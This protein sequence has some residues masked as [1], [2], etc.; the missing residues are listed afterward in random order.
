LVDRTKAGFAPPFSATSSAWVA[1]ANMVNARKN[2][3]LMGRP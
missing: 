1:V 2:R 3:I